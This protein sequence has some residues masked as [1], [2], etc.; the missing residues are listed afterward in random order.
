MSTLL[1]QL[2]RNAQFTA[3][4]GR[5]PRVH[6]GQQ[7]AMT[8][9]LAQMALGEHSDPREIAAKQLQQAHMLL[10]HALGTVEFY[11]K[12]IN[13]DLLSKPLSPE[14]W[15]TLPILERPALQGAGESI[16]SAKLPRGHKTVGVKQTSGSTGVP[17]K[18]WS[19]NISRLFWIANTARGPL[20][21]KW[22]LGGR[23]ASIRPEVDKPPGE[24]VTAS[25]WGP[26]FSTLRPT[27][28]AMALNIRTP[29]EQQAEWLESVKPDY[30]LSMPTNLRALAH[31]GADLSKLKGLNSYGE[32]L[33]ENVRQE[34]EE[35][36]SVPIFD[37]YSSQEVGYMSLQCKEAGKHHILSDTVLIEV[38]D[39]H[40]NPCAIGEPGRIVVTT[41]QNFSAPLI[42]YAIGDYGVLGERCACGRTLPTLDKILGRQRNM[43]RTPD[44]KE[45]WPSFPVKT[46]A[47]GLP[48]KQ[49][50]FV[51]KSLQNIKAML[52]VG[53]TLTTEEE[54]LMK[55][56][57]QT[58]F[59]NYPFQIDIEY[60]NEIT[61]SKGGKYE[62]FK[63][64]L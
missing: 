32:L 21:Q 7:A 13:P 22:D 55:T 33:E 47:E 41:L 54:D 29:I 3:A 14:R 35:Q 39:E 11:V 28:Q 38:L 64:E 37:M 48:V 12:R 51:Q 62:D 31:A 53:R 42:R 56:K 4:A 9:L 15:R 60:V 44:G 17:V 43:L 34:I 57:L 26:A 52:V 46:W 63:S 19:S 49:F 8:D 25:N 23:L 58:R 16:R 59:G 6:G 50:Q 27:G 45:H 20:W 36:T 24:S 40:G 2:Y 30:L 5:W 18:T 1:T 61:R 10:R